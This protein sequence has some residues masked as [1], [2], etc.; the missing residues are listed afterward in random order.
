MLRVLGAILLGLGGLLTFGNYWGIAQARRTKTHFS[1]IPIL[2]GLFGCV[3]MVLVAKVRWLAF[4][5][6]L[7]DVGCMPMLLALAF[8]LLSGKHR[9]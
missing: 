4:I 5:P 8:F 1:C 6:P 2:G 9:Q 7:A 3:G